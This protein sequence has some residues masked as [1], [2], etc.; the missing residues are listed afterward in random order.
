M[1]PEQVDQT[2]EYLQL[3]L[4]KG[5]VDEAVDLLRALHPSDGADVLMGLEPEPRAAIVDMLDA[6]E[7]ADVFEQLEDDELVEIS[8]HMETDKLADVLDEVEADVAADLLGD[9]DV[10]ESAQLLEQMEDASDVQALLTYDDESAGGIMNAPPPAIRRQLNAAEA[11]EFLRSHYRDEQDE[12]YYLYVVDRL[13]RLTGIVDLRRLLLASG[14]EIIDDI[15]DHRVLS[16]PPEMDQE[17]VAEMLAHYDLLALPVV[18]ENRHLIGVVTVDDVV[19]VFKEEATEDIYR[20]AQ[21]NAES[22]VFSP[23]PQSVRHRLP[24]LFVNLGTALL[25]A[26]VV[27]QFEGIIAQLALLAAFLPIVAAQGGNAGNQTMTIMVRS[28]ALGEIR[29]RDAWRTL[30]HELAVGLVHGLVLGISVGLVAWFW[31]GNPM[32]GAIIA[33]AM[34]ANLLIAAIVGVLVP[35]L[36]NVIG[37]DPALASGVFVTATTDI[38]GFAIFLGLA[39]YFLFWLL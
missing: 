36:L 34:I 24:W 15:M 22:E 1:N 39:S 28:L 3:L 9:L 38:M 35:N 7:I 12:L 4:E 21:L 17:E 2:V 11:I 13:N 10:V 14:D 20:L 31:Q 8:Q 25:A 27:A 5:A 32:L 33:L 6:A 23:I 30:R 26:T 29:P 18:D 16:V 19:D 37:I